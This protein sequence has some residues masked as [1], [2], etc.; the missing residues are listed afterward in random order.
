MV[1]TAEEVAEVAF[2]VDQY[3]AASQQL[4]DQAAAAVQSTWLSFEGWYDAAL[5]GAMAAQAADLSSTAQQ[6]AIGLSEQ[7][8]SSVTTV[9]AGTTAVGPVSIDPVRNGVD[10][11]LVHM[12][13]ANEYRKAFATGSTTEESMRRAFQRGEGLVRTDISLVE[14]EAQDRALQSLGVT[15]Y[16]RVIHPELSES[17]SCGLCV[18]AADRKYRTG[19]LMPI[20]PPECKCTVMPVVGDKDPGLD[21]NTADL[22]RIYEV[23][24]STYAKD[25]LNTRVTVNEHGELGSVLSRKGDSF[26]GPRKVALEDDPARAARMLDNTLP[27]LARL[28]AAGGPSDALTYQRDLVARL[29]SI[30]SAA[31]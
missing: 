10:P 21:L 3:A 4:K 8:V 30:T 28:E 5:V 15:T 31:A 16:R 20:H 2:L 25:L 23:A 1:A 6:L 17:G 12:R 19:E 29:R 18:V 26:R 24:G 9:L 22:K 7:Y 11:V 13:V 27:T 14:R